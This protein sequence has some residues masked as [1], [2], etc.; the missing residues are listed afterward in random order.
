M[1]SRGP[2]RTR[3]DH[4][5]ATAYRVERT[6]EAAE[7]LRWL[8]RHGR[9]AQAALVERSLDRFLQDEPGMERGARERMR[10]NRLGVEWALHLG[11]M[12]VYY[13]IDED[14]NV[15]WVVGVGEQPGNTLYLRGQPFDL[16]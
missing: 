9:K 13:E 4:G 11:V 3:Y 15:V 12:R 8:A 5:A 7:D 16:G 14:N 1:R 10:P 6:Q 2:R